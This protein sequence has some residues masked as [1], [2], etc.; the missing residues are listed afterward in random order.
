MTR[1]LLR[2]CPECAQRF[3]TER[4]DQTFCTPAHKASFHQRNSAR[5]RG[6]LVQLAIAWRTSRNRK[7][8]GPAGQRAF[9]ELCIM[10]DELA[11]QDKAAGRDAIAYLEAR[12]R[13]EGT[14][15]PREPLPP[16][17]ALKRP[18]ATQP[19]PLKSSGGGRRPP[20]AKSYESEG[21]TFESFRARHFFHHIR[22]ASRK[23]LSGG[24][25]V[26]ARG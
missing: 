21:R 9:R 20:R 25:C 26:L 15:A 24:R 14:M 5:G 11:R 10:L 1:K 18:A 3:A 19:I 22:R 2:T 6:G 13:A 8:G 4:L 16:A 12:W 7:D 23:R 17:R